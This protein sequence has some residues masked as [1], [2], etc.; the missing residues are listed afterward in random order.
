M[1]TIERG[2]TIVVQPENTVYEPDD[3]KGYTDLDC[4]ADS[5]PSSTYT[6]VRELNNVISVVDPSTSPR[7]TIINGRLIINKPSTE[8]KD[9][10][11]YQCR[12]SNPYGL[13][14]SNIA[15]LSGG[16]TLFIRS[17]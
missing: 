14:V 11:K 15:T 13:L 8:S 2:P 7:Y 1:A 9:D 12:P 3:I 4:L 10:G 6:W 5:Y 16:C 17:F